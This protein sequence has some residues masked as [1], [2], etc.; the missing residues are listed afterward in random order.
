MPNETVI[1]TVGKKTDPNNG[2]VTLYVKDHAW[3]PIVT[4]KTFEEAKAKFL[5]ALPA[6]MVA[7]SYC[8]LFIHKDNLEDVKKAVEAKKGERLKIEEELQE[9]Q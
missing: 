4:G 5:V 8:E 9:C 6:N 3:G 1:A 2:H 7:N